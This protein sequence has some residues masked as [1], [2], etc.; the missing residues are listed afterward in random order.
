M[1]K[2]TALKSIRLKCIDCCG[3]SANEVK[4]CTAESCPL[5]LLRFGK[6]PE[7]RQLSPEERE[8]RIKRLTEARKKAE[9]RK[10]G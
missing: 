1:S 8:R 5:H 4:L 7:R 9:E 2:A 6:D 10:E 3:G